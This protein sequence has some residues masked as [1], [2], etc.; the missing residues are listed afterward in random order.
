VRRKRPIPRQTRAAGSGA[1]VV[2][3][4]GVHFAE[5]KRFQDGAARVSFAIGDLIEKAAINAMSFGESH[6]ISLLLNRDSQQ[7]KNFA[8]IKYSASLPKSVRQ[9]L[10]VRGEFLAVPTASHAASPR[11]KIEAPLG[12]GKSDYGQ[13]IGPGRREAA[14]GRTAWN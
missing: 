1:S 7:L 9:V 3:V 12:S 11:T 13:R 8:V 2:L 14:G 4:E 10:T 6:L 5:S